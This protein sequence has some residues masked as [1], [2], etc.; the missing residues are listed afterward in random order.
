MTMT[1]VHKLPYKLQSENLPEVAAAYFRRQ[2]K[3]II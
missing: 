2:R 3:Q 1:E